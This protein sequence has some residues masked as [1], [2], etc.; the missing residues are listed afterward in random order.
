MTSGIHENPV[1]FLPLQTAESSARV[2][3]ETRGVLGG[4]RSGEKVR[5]NPTKEIRS[6]I[7]VRH[8]AFI[9]ETAV[10]LDRS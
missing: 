3:N 5:I 8:I 9:L 10:D 1:K 7:F 4:D 2:S 6:L